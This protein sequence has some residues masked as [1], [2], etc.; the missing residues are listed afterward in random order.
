MWACRQHA[1]SRPPT[2]MT[3]RRVR[4]HS[5]RLQNEPRL[6]I[7]EVSMTRK[8]S[9]NTEWPSLLQRYVD[10]TKPRP[11]NLPRRVRRRFHN[12]DVTLWQGFVHIDDVRGYA[13]NMR[14]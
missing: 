11:E 13:E 12:M 2:V 8:Q 10:E 4:C 9:A 3:T 1:A 14:L 7:T 6:R 5:L